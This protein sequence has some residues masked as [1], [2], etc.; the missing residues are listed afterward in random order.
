MKKFSIATV[1]AATLTAAVLG[2]S[3]PAFAAPTAHGDAQTT[4]SQLEAEGHRVIVNRLS[5][6]PLSEATVVS[7]KEGGD[8]RD[9]VHGNYEDHIYQ[10]SVTGH[11]YYVDVK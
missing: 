7:I 10:Q 6:R 3:A 2:L 4:I 1:A 9:T 8:I 11:V 5:D